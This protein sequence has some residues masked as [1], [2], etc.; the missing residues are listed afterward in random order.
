M[1]NIL[2]NI[3]LRVGFA[4][5]SV[6]K[7]VPLVTF[8]IKIQKF[9]YDYFKDGRNIIGTFFLKISNLHI[10]QRSFKGAA[11]PLTG[12][13][14]LTFFM[15]LTSKN[16]KCHLVHAALAPVLIFSNKNYIRMINNHEANE[17]NVEICSD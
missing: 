13:T 16:P 15:L 9:I 10:C 5:K 1:V 11:R 12:N 4:V 17:A 8:V 6:A 14:F 7:Q 2:A 3:T